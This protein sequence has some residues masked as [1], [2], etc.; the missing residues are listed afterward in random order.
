MLALSAGT[1]LG[2]QV[3][4]ASPMCF[5]FFTSF[6]TLITSTDGHSLVLFCEV[7]L[8]HK[9]AIRCFVVRIKKKRDFWKHF[10]LC[11]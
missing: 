5:S 2:H 1:P 7:M 4:V 9:F 10:A 8:L 6:F 11:S 3:A